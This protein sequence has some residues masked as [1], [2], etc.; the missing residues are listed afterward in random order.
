M[1]IKAK[2]RDLFDSK[3]FV[4]ILLKPLKINV[5]VCFVLMYPYMY[6]H[7]SMS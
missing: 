7:Y 3:L 1:Q 2:L 6:F 4:S 5:H